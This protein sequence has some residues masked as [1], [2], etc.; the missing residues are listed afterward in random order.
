MTTSLLQRPTAQLDLLLWSRQLQKVRFDEV[1]ALRFISNA[2]VSLRDAKTREL[3]PAGRYLMAH[4]GVY[5]LCLGTIYLHGMLPREQ[6]GSRA[7]AIQLA[8]ELLDMTVH[9][10]HQIL[11][12]NRHLEEIAGLAHATLGEHSV[13]EVIAL[14]D[15]ALGQAR[16]VY[17]DCFY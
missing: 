16:L 15:R 5:A 12:A 3:S 9:D 2:L 1:A 7:M 6:E 13:Q 17:P 8:F 10:L 11:Y 4:E 14:G